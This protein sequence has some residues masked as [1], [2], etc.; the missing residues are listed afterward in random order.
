MSKTDTTQKNTDGGTALEVDALD[1][2]LECLVFLT[3]HFGRAKSAEALTAGLAYDANGMGPNL[4]CEAAERLGLSAKIVKR[5]SVKRVPSSVLPAVLI[6]KDGH[7]CVLLSLS[8]NS[9]KAKIFSPET[10]AVREISVKDLKKDYAGYAIFIHPRSE[11]TNPETVHLEETGRHWFWGIV[12]ANRSVYAMVLLAAVF[13]NLFGLTSPL[14][15]MNVY[16]RVI[17]N[18]AIETGW[19]LGIGALAV[20]V[21]DLIM[22]TVRSYMIDLSGRR[23]DVIAARRIYDQVIN[24]KLAGRPKSSG[25]FANMLRD[26]DSVR[27]FFTSATITGLVD[28]PFTLIFLFVIYQL[29]GGIAFILA[30]LILVVMV[31]GYILQFPLKSYVRKSVQA[32]EAKHGLLVETIHGLETIKAVGA[33]GSFRARY[34]DYVGESAAYGQSSRFIS[35]LGVNIATFLQQIASII[36][37]L[38]GMY[39]VQDGDLTVGGLIACVILGGRAI[40]PVGQIAN[41]MTRYHQAGG[42]LKTLNKIMEAPVERPPHKQFLHRPDLKGHIAFEKV[43]FAYPGVDRKVLDNISFSIKPGEK[44]GIIGRIGSGKST[45]ARLMMGLYDPDSG[46][47]LADD[48]DYRQIDPADLRRNI[49]Y[50]AQ[51]VVLFGGSVRD[52]IAASLPHASEEAILEAAKA[53]G[54][55]EFISRHPMGYDAPV[56]EHGG[57]LSGGQRQAVALARAMLL[58]PHVMVCDEPTNAMDMQAEEAFGRYI[59]NEIKNRTLILITHKTAMLPLVE[60][61]ILMDQG[62]VIM[63]GPRDKVI[64]SLNTGKIEVKS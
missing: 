21:F 12:Q 22:R 35:G 52:N 43:S 55:H 39:M 33:D 41:L 30:G 37:V 49:A 57:G 1:P 60:R 16:D 2:L 29:G 51:D 24:M 3:S 44:V 38:T 47:I 36:I 42:A 48:T 63:D 54:V 53:A 27:E 7:V 23:I 20:F 40:A 31:V 14:F 34:G 13:I 32:S 64:E 6:L 61:L 4:F 5:E 45:I 56:G 26:F 19:A 18:N 62:R 15:I 46:S 25:A 10:K 17:P 50:I 9:K 28:L 11:F 59:Q 8:S 58:N